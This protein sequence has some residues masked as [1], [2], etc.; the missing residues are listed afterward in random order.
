MCLAEG[1]K[2]RRAIRGSANEEDA[3]F[4]DEEDRN[5]APYKENVKYRK[6]KH[7]KDKSKYKLVK[8]SYKDYYYSKSNKA[9]K[10][11]YYYYDYKSSKKAKKSGYYY[12][13]STN[14]PSNGDTE[15]STAGETEAVSKIDYYSY[16]SSKSSS[17]HDKKGY[18]SSKSSKYDKASKK[19]NYSGDYYS[20][21]SKSHKKYGTS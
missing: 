19:G 10:K 9:D 20:K 15:A 8:K 11:G 17:K 13:Q 4:F 7:S 12:Y 3:H 1:R 5:L 16:Y 6:S 21:K 14:E 2:H 18:Y